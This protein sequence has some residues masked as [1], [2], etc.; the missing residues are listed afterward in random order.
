MKDRTLFLLSLL[1]VLAGCAG[2]SPQTGAMTPHVTAAT[3]EG[4]SPSFTV[5]GIVGKRAT[6]D[7]AAL[8]AQP[9]VTLT[10]GS[11]TYTGVSLWTLLNDAS[12]GLKPDTAVRNP[13][14]SMYAVV[15]GSDGYRAVVS[16]AEIAPESGNRMALVAYSLNGTPLGRNGMARLVVA[17]DVKPGRSVARLAAIEVFAAQPSGR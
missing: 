1:T 12:V 14:L 16:L 17:G 6:F 4:I 2:G 15:V 8:Q 10:V 9:A 11:N 5:S 7:L 13:V 3:N